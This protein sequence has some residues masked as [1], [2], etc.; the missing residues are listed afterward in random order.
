MAT[1]GGQLG[2]DNHKG[3]VWNDALRVAI[4][5]DDGLR[6][7]LAA[8]K[9]IDLAADGTPWAIKE[10]ADRL[11]G[12]SIQGVEFAGELT[13]HKRAEELTDDELATIA[14]NAINSSE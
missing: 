13:I 14:A 5:S 11:D 12:K 6:V 9:L 2:N 1:K 3:K 8:E 10:L 7:R 4:K